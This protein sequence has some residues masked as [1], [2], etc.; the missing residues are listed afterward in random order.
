MPSGRLASVDIQAGINT[1]I[2]QAPGGRAFNVTVRVV[3]RND[4]DVKIR[5]AL[6]D[7]DLST[8]SDD[9]WGLEYDTI[10][11][12]NGNLERYKVSMAGYQ[13]IIGYS[14]TSN[15]TFQVGGS[16]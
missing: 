9:D 4:V 7:G 16:D 1:L 8:L 3:N 12:A 15:V 6:T 14:D 13:S 11:R 5:L 10:I 2:Y